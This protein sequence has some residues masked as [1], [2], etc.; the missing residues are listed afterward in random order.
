MAQ[1]THENEHL[2]DHVLDLHIVIGPNGLCRCGQDGIT[3]QERLRRIS[4]EIADCLLGAQMTKDFGG[5][6]FI[7]QK[8]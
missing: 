5:K 6:K 8:P 4:T 1:E 7:P 2:M 3:C